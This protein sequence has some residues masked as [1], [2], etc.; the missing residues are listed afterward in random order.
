VY[1]ARGEVLIAM[2]AGALIVGAVGGLYLSQRRKLGD[3]EQRF[4]AILKSANNAIL[5]EAPY[6]IIATNP[7]GEVTL[8][9]P[10]AERMLATPP[11][12]W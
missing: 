2:L 9:N 1:S 11:P 10:A 6:A 12:T 7:E 5:D 4:A 8:F 3:Y